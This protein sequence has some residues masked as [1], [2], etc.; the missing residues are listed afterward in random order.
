M[1]KLAIVAGITLL[2]AACTDSTLPTA[3]TAVAGPTPPVATPP[4]P[5]NVPGVLALSMP[6]DPADAANTLFGIAPYGYHATDHAQDGHA[7]WDIE[8]RP[9]G[10]VRAAAA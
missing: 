10:V 4:L 8:Y 1:R 9:G 3:P 7:G 2:A 6:L 5:T